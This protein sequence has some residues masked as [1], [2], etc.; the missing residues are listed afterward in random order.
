MI[1]FGPVWASYFL[2]ETDVV[3]KESP[4]AALLRN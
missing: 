2:F 1:R 4:E 3:F